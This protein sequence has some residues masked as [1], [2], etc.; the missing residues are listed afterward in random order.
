MADSDEVALVDGKPITDL[1]VVDLK[2]HLDK[3]G[4][5]KAGSKKELQ[6]RLKAVSMPQEPHN[7]PPTLPPS[8]PQTP[9]FVKKR[10][11]FEKGK[12]VMSMVARFDGRGFLY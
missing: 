9:P 8:S 2:R 11:G 1:R 5:S 4:L 12:P 10:C 6:E 3:R 7:A